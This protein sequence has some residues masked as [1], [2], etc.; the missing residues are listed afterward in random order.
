MRKYIRFLF[1]AAF[2]QLCIVSCKNISPDKH[3]SENTKKRA[4]ITFKQDKIDFG[5]IIDGEI[6]KMNFTF[7]NNG[8]VP[9]ILYDVQ[10]GCGCTVTQWPKNPIK[11]N[12]IDTIK[13]KFNSLNKTGAQKKFLAIYSNSIENVKIVTFT[14]NVIALKKSI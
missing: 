12:E 4:N 6:T 3:I 5:T 14:G 2:F 11:P 8:D 10:T 13:V 1:V 9:L 7:T